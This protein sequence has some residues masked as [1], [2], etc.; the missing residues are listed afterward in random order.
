[1]CRHLCD[2]R[3]ADG[4]TYA[5]PGVIGDVGSEE[6]YGTV[7]EDLK[8]RDVSVH[9]T[10]VALKWPSRQNMSIQ[11]PLYPTIRNDVSD[12]RVPPLDK[13]EVVPCG[14]DRASQLL[15]NIVG[16][17]SVEQSI[18]GKQRLAAEYLEKMP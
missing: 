15:L 14:D 4:P 7:R 10:V 1:M 3:V 2:C 9:Q 5:I 12:L 18:V 11:R 17:Y 13:R 6:A 8:P 16:P